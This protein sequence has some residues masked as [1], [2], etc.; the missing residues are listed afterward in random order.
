[1]KI[2]HALDLDGA[3]SRAFRGVWIGLLLAEVSSQESEM[4]TRFTIA[5][6]VC[7]SCW[8]SLGCGGDAGQAPT[9]LTGDIDWVVRMVFADQHACTGFVLIE[10]WLLTAGHCVEQARPD[11]HLEVRQVVFGDRSVLYD[12]RAELILHP[13]YDGSADPTHRWNDV[14]LVG[15]RDGAIE[16]DERARLAGLDCSSVDEAQV[17]ANLYA[18][19]YGHEPDPDT[20]VCSDVLGSKKRYDGF[21]FRRVL[22]PLVDEPRE[23]ELYGREDALCDGDSGAPLLFD[24]DGVPHAFAVFSGNALVRAIFYGSLIGPKIGWLEEATALT[25]VPLRCVDFGADSWECF[26]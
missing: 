5:V 7:C 8:S 6:L 13:D 24:R 3:E 9:R 18:I 19:G 11:G 21:V 1:V 4:N 26:E 2:R 25:D 10:H 12:G 15:L 20:G 16:A 14:A 22:G 23:V 17:Q